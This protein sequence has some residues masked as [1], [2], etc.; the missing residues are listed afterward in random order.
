MAESNRTKRKETIDKILAAL[1]SLENEI[2]EAK[3]I[4]RGLGP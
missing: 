4:L 3:K 1:D 2:N